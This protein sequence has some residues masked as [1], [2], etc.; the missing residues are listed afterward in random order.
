ME[1]LTIEDVVFGVSVDKDKILLSIAGPGI[2]KA[3]GAFTELVFPLTLEKSTELHA[4][5]EH[6]IFKPVVLYGYD[7]GIF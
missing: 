6:Y 5:L 4:V 2:E 7:G 3:S 1:T